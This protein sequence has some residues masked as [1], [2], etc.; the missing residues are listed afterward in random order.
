M[1]RRDWRLWRAIVAHPFQMIIFLFRL[2]LISHNLTNLRKVFGF[3]FSPGVCVFQ[4]AL[5]LA[6]TVKFARKRTLASR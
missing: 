6:V 5:K 4:K 1:H 2:Q 3:I